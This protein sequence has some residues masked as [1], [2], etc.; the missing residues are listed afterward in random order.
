MRYVF[1]NIPKSL[2]LEG[3]K[4]FYWYKSGKSQVKVTINE[5]ANLGFLFHKA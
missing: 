2:C 1:I 4:L 5:A 3:E